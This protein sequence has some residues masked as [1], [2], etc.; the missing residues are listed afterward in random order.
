MLFC[1]FAKCNSLREVSGA[2]LGLSGKTDHFQLSHIPKRSTLSD[3]N[4]NR[5][6][7][8]FEDIYNKLLNQYGSVLSDS[9][10]KDVKNKQVKIL[11]I[12]TISLF[13]D[14]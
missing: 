12:S 2:M 14:I 8:F 4:K 1:S 7:E 3:A 13:K 10:I 5:K 9:R 6:V 11:D